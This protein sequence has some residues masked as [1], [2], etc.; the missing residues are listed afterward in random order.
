M[1]ESDFVEVYFQRPVRPNL[2]IFLFLGYR[3]GNRALMVR[4][5]MVGMIIH[6]N[7]WLELR[8]LARRY[9]ICIDEKEG[10]YERPNLASKNCHHYGHNQS[11]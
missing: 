9:G 2:S 6:K 10:E 8:E 4:D 11:R 3:K 7:D 1:N 5:K